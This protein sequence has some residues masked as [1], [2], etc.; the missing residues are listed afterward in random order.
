M[1]R[2]VVVL[3]S[4]TPSLFWF[5]MD[6]MKEFLARGW[7]VYAIA[8]E[9]VDEWSEKFSEQGIEYRQISIQRNGMNPIKDIKALNSIKKVLSE[10]GPDKIF[11][12][13]AKTVIYGSIAANLLG[14]FEVYP[15]IAGMGS[16]FLNHG[17]KAKIVRTILTTEYRIALKR[18]PAV[19]FQN[20]DD[21]SVFRQY[22]ILRNQRTVMLHGSGVNTE[23]FS[24][25]QI[26]LPPVFICISRLIRDKGV[27]EYLNACRE[28]KRKH[29]YIRCLLVGPYDTNPTAI[30]PE[31]IQEF[32]VDG[33][34]EY[35]GETDDVRPFLS[36]S[37]VFVLPSYR[38]GT[39]KT[40]L[41]A[42]A[43]GR[44]VITTDAPGC[45]ETV[46]D[47][48]NGFLVPVKDIKALA[49]RMEW[50]IDHTDEIERMGK[51]GRKMAEAIFDVRK[52]DDA[53]CDTM[54]IHQ[55]FHDL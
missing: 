12:F 49:E 41:E 19:F 42:M 3:S 32:V 22:R 27:G 28:I 2:K 39:P 55:L 5:R 23:K 4:H 37:S 45:R 40:N 8:N 21:E 34:I 15:L 20:N 7:K 25:S 36:Q 30:T 54:G 14:I 51:I 48:E 31:E 53:I 52:V 38:E 16:V 1:E 11:A 46:N 47:G 18:C 6:M 44:A 43:C 29:H 24:V 13:Q 10:I 17:A 9:A 26:P 33:S 50:F 35:F